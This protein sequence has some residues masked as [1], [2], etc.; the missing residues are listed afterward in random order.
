V[1]MQ[2][3]FPSSGNPAMSLTML[4]PGQ[5]ATVVAI[6]GGRGI[7]QR[8]ASMGVY[9]G[10]ELSLV[11]GAMPGPVIVAVN[12]ARFVLGRGMA[13]KVMVSPL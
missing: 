12:Q 2:R 9:P 11:R 4:N 10:V 6:Q 13:H 8:L 3:H 7:A 1:T 5:R